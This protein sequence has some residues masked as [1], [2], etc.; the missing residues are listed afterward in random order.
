MP[1]PQRPGN[2][3]LLSIARCSEHLVADAAEGNPNVKPR[4]KQMF[5]QCGRE[6]AVVTVAI[7]CTK[8]RFGSVGDKRIS[9][10][11]LNDAQ[12]GH[13]TAHCGSART[14]HSAHKR[15]VAARV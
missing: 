15:I 4:L 1:T 6:G 10:R 2:E 7:F 12:S 9:G 14:L 8:T 11:W 13:D 3:R 5:Q